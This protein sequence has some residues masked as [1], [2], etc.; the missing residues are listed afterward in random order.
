MKL[1]ILFF[2]SSLLAAGVEL[3]LKPALNFTT[4]EC[5]EQVRFHYADS[6]ES[7]FNQN[8][9]GPDFEVQKL[10]KK[11]GLTEL[12][13]LENNVF[14]RKQFITALIYYIY[15]WHDKRTSSCFHKAAPCYFLLKNF[16]Y[17]LDENSE[18]KIYL[19]EQI[20]QLDRDIKHCIQ[21]KYYQSLL[22]KVGL[23]IAFSGILFTVYR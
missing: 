5:Y 4:A 8:K 10:A 16:Y 7:F 19:V 6:V 3:D 1:G 23:T 22:T 2:C 18:M 15:Q 20:E 13:G 12:N 14:G 9:V 17:N 11:F 21:K